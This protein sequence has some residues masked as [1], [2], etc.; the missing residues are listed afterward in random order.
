MA[1]FLFSVLPARSHIYPS[2]PIAYALRRAGH[3][4]AYATFRQYHQLLDPH[5]IAL[6]PLVRTASDELAHAWGDLREEDD[7]REAGKAA[8]RTRFIAPMP[9]AV[10]NLQQIIAIWQPDVL[11]ND[12]VSYAP[13]IVGELENLPVA[14]MNNTIFEWPGVDLGPFS[15]GLPPARDAATRAHYAALRAESEAFYAD[16]VDDLNAARAGF[17]LPQRSGPL[18]V[19]TLSP[20]LHMLQTIPEFDYERTDLPPQAHYVGPCRFTPPVDPDPTIASWLAGLLTG[21]RLVLVTASLAFPRS[22]G[23]VQAALDGLAGSSLAVLATLPWDHPLHYTLTTSTMRLTRFVPYE[24]ALPRCDV[25]VTHGGFGTVTEA[26]SYGL[27]LVV[28]PYA[29]DQPQVAQRVATAEA[30]LRLDAA[31]LTPEGVRDAVATVLQE[32]RYRAGAQRLAAAMARRN[33]PT[34][35]VALLT[36]LAATRQPILRDGHDSTEGLPVDQ[37]T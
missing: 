36:H 21:Q 30:G 6:F 9:A 11:I 3:A 27:P 17:G 8:F 13:L 29:S 26:L 20:Y 28:V 15:E 37:A 25:V 22:A 2:L 34:E 32:N 18:P 14:T 16:L 1:R 33:G 35:S 31:T 12:A 19:A 24:L 4:V 23:L 5:G 7:S 10:R